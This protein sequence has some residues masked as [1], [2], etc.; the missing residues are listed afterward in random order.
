MRNQSVMI[1]IFNKIIFSNGRLQDFVQINKHFCFRILESLSVA[2]ISIKT[3]NSYTKVFVS[4]QFNK[5]IN[6]GTNI[7]KIVFF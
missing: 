2:L 5:I 7:E 1:P 6:C 4:L 3:F